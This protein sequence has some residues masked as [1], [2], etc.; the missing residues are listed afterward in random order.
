M[1]WTETLIP[2]LRETPKEAE[3]PSHRWLVRGGFIRQLSS[4]V[5]SYLPLGQRV[6]KKI[7]QIIRE[8]MNGAGAQELLMPMVQPRELW[9]ES[10]RWPEYGKELLRFRDR[11]ERDFC[12]G[13]THE[14][15]VTDIVRNE[16]KSYRQ[17]PIKL[18][19]IQTKFRDEIR[20]RFG[21]M[22]G[23]EFQMKDCYSF[24]LDEAGARKSYQGMFEA[25]KRIFSRCG[26]KFRPVEAGTG[27]IGGS[28]SHEFHVLANSGEDEIFAC[29][30]CD[31][32]ASTDKAPANKKCPKGDGALRSHRGIEVGQVFY[33]GTKYS[34][35]L[36]A[37]YL[38]PQGKEQLIEMGCYGIGVGRTAAAAIEQN[39]DNQGIIWPLPIAPYPVALLALGQGEV[40][41][42]S[43]RLYHEM[44]DQK[45]E[46]LFDD[47][48]ESAGVKFKD[49]DLIGIPWRIQVGQKGLARGEVELKSRRT[50]E[51]ALVKKENVMNALKERLF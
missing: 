19:Q 49:A 28:L 5:Y 45:I 4:G 44:G 42:V 43:Q 31:Y 9:E 33:L 50:G 11:H 41:E 40:Q 32:A 23:R 10:G 51:I 35:K 38:D 21:L 8:E 37:V 24:D 46:V 7:S 22:R 16:V 15:V 17:L 39:H 47:R 6:L 18:Y 20:P 29:D 27:L 13:P 36:H 48:D 30:Q 26:L 2:T 14:E 3:A 1:R 34:K 25:Y 12:L